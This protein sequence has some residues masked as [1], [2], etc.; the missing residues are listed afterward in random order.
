MP[1][2]LAACRVGVSSFFQGWMMDDNEMHSW[3][4]WEIVEAV[5]CVCGVVI[6][7]IILLWRVIN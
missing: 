4:A 7:E 5:V 2:G 6:I 3:V 1:S